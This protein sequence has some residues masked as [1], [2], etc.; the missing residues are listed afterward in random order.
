VFPPVPPEHYVKSIVADFAWAEERMAANPVYFTLNACRVYAYLLEAHILSKD[1][2]GEWAIGR[3][4]EAFQSVVAQ[5]LS[6]YRGQPSHERI[7]AQALQAF[8]R[9]IGERLR[10]LTDS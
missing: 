5:A 4:S 8:A 6:S 2:A 1:E 3:L 7:D 10:I 9:Y